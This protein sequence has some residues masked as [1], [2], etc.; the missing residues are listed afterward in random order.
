MRRF[1]YIVVGAG[2]AG[3]VLAHRLSAD[4]GNRVLL[5]EAGGHDQGN[6][7][8]R[9]PRG[10]GEL[11]G[12]PQT[13]CH[14]PTRPFGPD[15]KVEQWV[16][17]RTLG[18]S[19][20]V[21]GMVYNRGEG[22]DYNALADLGN[23]GWG[24][25]DILPAFT[26]IE[27]HQL[28]A[29]ETRGADGPLQ[30]S[31]ADEG[32]SLLEDVLA[33]G[34]QLGWRRVSDLNDTEGERIG[35]A[36]A[37]IRDGRRSSAADAFLHPVTNRRNLTVHLRTCVDR[38]VLDDGRAVGIEGRRDGEAVEYRATRE[39]IL[40]A[41][42]LAT[43]KILQ[44][45]GIG[46]RDTL[47]SAGVEQRVDSPNVGRRLREHRVFTLQYRLTDDVGY[48]RFLATPEGQRQAIAE[49]EETGG[50][51]MGTPSFD[52]MGLFKSRPKM[53]RPDA[54]LQ[55]APF[56]MLPPQPGKGI[57]VEREP[58]LLCIAYPLRPTS[59][60]GV[61]ITASDPDASMDID[62][63]YLTAHADRATTVDI[64]RAVRKL[65]T[66]GPLK[67]WIGHETAPGDAVQTDQEIIDAGLR[68]GSAGYHAIGTAA[69]GPNDDDV[70]D[71][72]LCVR[73]V[74][75]LRVMDASVLPIMISGNLN[76]PVMA[77]A[78]RAADFI[79]EDA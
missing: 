60:G 32:E 10:F 13:V 33:A 1:D 3:C 65:F 55:I 14:Y 15:Q 73:G 71:S 23:E 19:S 45:S 34:T 68:T 78:W 63:G 20:S 70:V 38:I 41:G 43:P 42:T 64:V 36:A 39:V 76:G 59:E 46:D 22:A 37:T 48:N 9:M 56:S 67:K 16:R 35:Y 66:V 47:R 6:P 44:L 26:T 58:G 25:A 31:T 74:S 77:M 4:P 69:M 2:S 79:L 11:L 57:Q 18:G 72:R 54:Q 21:N 12:D 75:G 49:Y 61:R 62:P 7:L 8:I 27:D 29:S 28:G 53:N 40:A 52:L 24:W 50:G 30:I 5:V 17:G 51:P